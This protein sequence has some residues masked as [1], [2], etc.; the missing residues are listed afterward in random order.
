[1]SG[2]RWEKPAT[3][4]GALIKRRGNTIFVALPPHA[5]TPVASGGAVGPDCCCK[6]CKAG[7]APVWDTLVIS[8]EPPEGGRLDYATTCHYP[9]FSQRR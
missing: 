6:Q 3:L 1:M 8:A 9:E 5:W 7:A 2:P 4:N